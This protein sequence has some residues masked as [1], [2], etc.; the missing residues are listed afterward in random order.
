MKKIL[1]FILFSNSLISFSQENEIALENLIKLN[2]GTQGA[3][4]A[5][6]IPVAKRLLVDVSTG[7]GGY[8]LA[9]RSLDGYEFSNKLGLAY[10]AKGELK[11]YISR[12]RRSRKD[13]D[14]VNNA[15]SFIALQSKFNNNNA[16]YGKIILNEFHFGQQLPLSDNL[17]FCYHVGLGRISNLDYTY[18]KVMPTIGL[19][20]A[21][22]FGGF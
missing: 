3:D 7:F 21:Y 19:K 9:T 6:E 11:Y 2:V 8:N 18:N 22:V 13:H 16:N 14:L 17:L 1:A 15:G 12:N 10:F 4:V 5:V 20:M